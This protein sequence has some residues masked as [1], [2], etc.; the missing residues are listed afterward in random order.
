[1]VSI[2]KHKRVL[3]RKGISQRFA[4]L[5][6]RAESIGL[7]WHT[8]GDLY[9]AFNY[10]YPRAFAIETKRLVALGHDLETAKRIAQQN[11]FR[12]GIKNEKVLR[13]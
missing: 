11:L 1:M 9:K 3:Q 4:R 2:I 13:N 7:K 5:A 12:A 6:N 10:S 8:A